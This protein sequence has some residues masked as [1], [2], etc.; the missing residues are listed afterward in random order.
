MS[1]R[2][3]QC[4]DTFTMLLLESSSQ[5]RLF[6]HLSDY[7]FGGGNFE[8]T[9]AIRVIFF[10]KRSKFQLEFKKAAKNQENVFC[11]WDNCIWIGIVKLSLLRT[12]YFSLATNVLTSIT[13][14]WHVN[15]REFSEHNFLASDEWF[16]SRCCDPNW[17]S[18]LARLWSCLSNHPLKGDFL[19]IF[20]WL[21][22]RSQ[23][24]RNYKIFKRHLFSQNV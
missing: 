9:K 11:F 15:K 3:E 17:N 24:F 7:V 16:S 4:L 22:F 5:T 19:D 20:I 10:S 18:V 1:C 13:K 21:R 8:N 12:G 23:Y 14:I 2:Y 6:R